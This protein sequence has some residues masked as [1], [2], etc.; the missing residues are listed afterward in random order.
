MVKL[1]YIKQVSDGFKEAIYVD[2][3]YTQIASE[4]LSLLSKDL[5]L[6]YQRLKRIQ[7][8]SMKI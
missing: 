2:K 3:N 6:E 1:T 4:Y 7:P 5:V 8:L